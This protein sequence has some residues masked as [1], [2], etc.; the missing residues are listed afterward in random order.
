MYEYKAMRDDPRYVGE[1]TRDTLYMICR[2]EVG[3]P[4]DPWQPMPQWGQFSELTIEGEIS[5]LYARQARQAALDSSSDMD[6]TRAKMSV[7]PSESN[8]PRPEW[9][10][11]G[12]ID[13]LTVAWGL[14]YTTSFNKTGDLKITDASG[15][16][17]W[18]QECILQNGS[19]Y[20]RL[21][22]RPVKDSR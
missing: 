11:D 15:T 13:T 4:N 20:L 6:Q 19:W 9:L 10:R 7:T 5:R 14:G 22:E 16:L 1:P 12:L 21:V 18:A 3:K 17:A 8:L 2:R